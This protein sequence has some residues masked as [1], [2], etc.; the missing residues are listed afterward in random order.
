MVDLYRSR[1]TGQQID[2]ALQA[3][4]DYLTNGVSLT[5]TSLTITDGNDITVEAGG[6]IIMKSAT[7][8]P[9]TFIMEANTRTFNLEA[10]YDYDAFYVYPDTDKTGDLRFGSSAG[11]ADVRFDT[12]HFKANDNVFLRADNDSDVGQMYIKP[13]YAEFNRHVQPLSNGSQDLGTGSLCWDNV[14]TASGTSACSDKKFKK[15]IVESPFGL[16]FINKLDSVQWEWDSDKFESSNKREILGWRQTNRRFHGMLAQDVLT[17]VEDMG[18][19]Y[20][21]FAGIKISDVIDKESEE[22]IGENYHL[23]Y[24]QFISPIIKSIQELSEEIKILK[25]EE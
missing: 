17:A 24:S 13:T 2:T 18:Y 12:I 19:S 8:N 4:L 14:F 5:T 21:D 9:S 10:H 20:S 15:N 11:V 22:K 1:F 16:D 23:R 6:D 25:G 3:S 7:G